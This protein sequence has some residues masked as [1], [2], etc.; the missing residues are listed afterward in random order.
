MNRNITKHF[1]PIPFFLLLLTLVNGNRLYAQLPTCI[2]SGGFVYSQSGNNIYNLDP[3]LPLSATNPSLNTIVLPPNSNGLAVSTN[4]NNVAGPSPTFYTVTNG[5]YYYYDGTNWVNTNH[6]AALSAVNLGGGGGFVYNLVGFSGQVYKYDGTGNDV[7]LTTIPDFAGGGPFDLQLDCAGNFYILRTETPQWMRKYSPTGTLLQSWTLT[8]AP[9]NSPGGGF[10]VIDDKVYYNNPSGYVEGTITGSTINFTVVNPSGLNPSPGDFASCPLGGAPQTINDTVFYCNSIAGATITSGGTAPFSYTV[11]NG[12]A[13][14]TGSGPSFNVKATAPATV[15]LHSTSVSI[16]SNGTLTD[17]FLVIPPPAVDA[18]VNDTIHGCGAYVDTLS[19]SLGN[20]TSWVNYSISWAPT[21][22]IVSGGTTMTPV[23]NPM[24]NTT[25]I[26]TITTP[27]T[28]GDCS[29][30]DSVIK[31]LEDESVNP[32]Y[33]FT[34]SYGCTADTVRFTNTSGQSTANLWDF[35]DGTTDTAANPVHIYPNQAMYDVRL[36][37]SNYLCTDS[38]H[39]LVDTRHPLVADF[40]IDNDTICQN[41]TI[42]FTNTST[43]SV[44]PGTY[45]WDFGDGATATGT[46]TSHYYTRSGVYDVRMIATDHVPCSDTVTH[47]VVVDSIPSLKF[48]ISDYDIC[49]GQSVTFTAGYTPIGNIGLTWDMGNGVI[50]TGDDVVTHSYQHAGTYTISLTGDYRV[51]HDTTYTDTIVVSPLPK[52]NLGPDTTICLDGAPLILTNLLPD[53]PGTSYS[54]NT[55][56][57]TPV[58]T[59]RHQGIYSLR[60]TTDHDCSS[61]DEVEVRKDCYV[62]IPNSFTPNGDGAN[63]Y[64][65]PRQLL[66]KSVAGFTMQIFNRWGQLLYETSQPDGRGWDGRFNDKEQPAG[67]YIYIINTVLKNQRIEKH[68]GNVTLLR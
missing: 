22:S 17:T 15:L 64:F 9:S 3:T 66:S 21:A 35:G 24:V 39:Q 29:I 55:G 31:T 53:M 13:T 18:G 42:T 67:V 52:V 37:A 62:D 12:S 45:T 23:V 28:Q 32:D 54:W 47:T 38:A 63:D 44:Q 68:T 10:A 51:C 65:F 5:F 61:T 40:T 48:T 14:V 25:Y 6:T 41:N 27:A 46:N 11:L 56:D 57:T 34:I 60:V 49:T 58:L 59:V 30:R 33:T 1:L 20:T 16:C 2:G 8:G 26:V 4:L 19:G 50:L 36:L 7:L 43:V